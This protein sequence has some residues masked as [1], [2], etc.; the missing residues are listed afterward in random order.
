M[1][2]ACV[3][4]LPTHEFSKR[5]SLFRLLPRFTLLS[6]SGS[7]AFWQLVSRVPC[8]RPACFLPPTPATC[9]AVRRF[10]CSGVFRCLPRSYATCSPPARSFL[11]LFFF[12]FHALP[13]LNFFS[14]YP[15]LSAKPI[16]KMFAALCSQGCHRSEALA[17]LPPTQ[18]IGFP[19]P[20]SVSPSARPFGLIGQSVLGLTRSRLFLPSVREEA[21]G[22]LR[23][24]IPA[25]FHE[26]VRP[27]LSAGPRPPKSTSPMGAQCDWMRDRVTATQW[28][29]T[30]RRR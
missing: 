14:S 30:V 7:R 5:V 18:G 4:G 9:V 26:L 17:S 3:G 2:F 23:R 13:I 19:N 11:N 15:P 21:L 8:P 24:G 20:G 1:V 22:W 12:P 27:R 6:G 10:L 28:L 25:W 16:D 29:L